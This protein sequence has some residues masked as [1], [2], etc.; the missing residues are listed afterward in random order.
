MGIKLGAACM[1]SEHVSD[2]ATMPGRILVAYHFLVKNIYQ[3]CDLGATL[4]SA[5]TILCLL[6]FI[7]MRL[8]AGVAHSGC[9]KYSVRQ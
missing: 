3:S 8:G 1:P 4:S 7:I 9:S 5:N 6:T 2:R